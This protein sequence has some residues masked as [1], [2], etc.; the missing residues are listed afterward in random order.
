ME[1]LK[2]N[3]ELWNL[4]TRAEEYNTG[5]LDKHK[6]FLY[7][8]SKYQQIFEPKVSEFLVKD[9]FKFQW[10]DNHKFAVCL[11]HDIDNIYPSW[12]YRYFTSLKFATRFQWQKSLD[13][14][15]KKE[16]P[17]WNFRKIMSLEKKY[18]AKSSFYIMADNSIYTAIELK[19][20]LM[21]IID[22]SNEV[23]LHGGY[24]AYSNLDL[25]KDE[26]EK[27]EKIAGKKIIG[28]RNHYLNFKI[29]D[30]WML[31][32]KAGF[33]YDATLGYVDS[34]GFRNGMCHPFKPFD[35]NS[36][37]QIDILEIPLTIMDDTLFQYMNLNVNESWQLCKRLIDTAKELSGVITILWHN[38]FFDEI[39][40]KDLGKL[41]EKILKYSH[42]KNGLLTSGEEILK[43][44]KNVMK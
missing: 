10:P 34:V 25:I 7:H 36:N 27:L 23:G 11:T 29:P 22:N 41:Y 39:Y 6:R 26:K 4:F 28:Y 16:N 8:H 9:G 31:L 38:T 30:T 20:E 43:I 24:H 5:T 19:D 32:Q 17:Y 18:D 15:S 3:N 37:E 2:K 44:W 21:N 35:L 14:F 12:K 40:R 42:E 1:R 13:R 33:K